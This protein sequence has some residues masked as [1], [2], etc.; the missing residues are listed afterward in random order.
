LGSTQDDVLEGGTGNDHL[1]GG[2]NNDVLFGR[3][4]DDVL[5]GLPGN[6]DHLNAGVGTNQCDKAGNGCPPTLT[7]CPIINSLEIS[8]SSLTPAL[9]NSLNVMKELGISLDVNQ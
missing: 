1:Y 5:C 6:K 4:G 7:P 2:N 9:T 8:S 3:D